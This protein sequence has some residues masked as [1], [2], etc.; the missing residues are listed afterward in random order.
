[1]APT[2]GKWRLLFTFIFVVCLGSG[3]RRLQ[4]ELCLDHQGVRKACSSSSSLTV[5]ASLK[6]KGISVWGPGVRLLPKGICEKRRGWKQV[7]AVKS[8]LWSSTLKTSCQCSSVYALGVDSQSISRA[9]L[10]RCWWDYNLWWLEGV[11]E[12]VCKSRKVWS[13]HLAWLDQ[14][15]GCVPWVKQKTL[16]LLCTSSTS[17]QGR[18]L[19]HHYIAG[20]LCRSDFHRIRWTINSKDLTAV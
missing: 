12:V 17:Y 15:E 19:Q 20:N 5:E 9:A 4:R 11:L 1:M 3:P 7:Y 2:V 13:W 6:P 10:D 14:Q 8:Q 18:A 16:P